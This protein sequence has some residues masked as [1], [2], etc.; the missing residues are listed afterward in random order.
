MGS[1]RQ[2]EFESVNH[3]GCLGGGGD[4]FVVARC[5]LLPRHVV[6]QSPACEHVRKGAQKLRDKRLCVCYQAT[7]RED[8]T[9]REDITCASELQTVRIGESAIFNC[10][11][12]FKVQYI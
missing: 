7:T 3:G 2:P 9:D 10:G 12:H 4:L 11:Q 1:P 8:T 5:I 6:R